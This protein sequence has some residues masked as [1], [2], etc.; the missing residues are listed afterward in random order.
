M[1]VSLCIGII[2]GGFSKCVGL[3]LRTTVTATAGTW[4]PRAFSAL[5]YFGLPVTG[6][7]PSAVFNARS[8]L[9]LGFRRLVRIILKILGRQGNRH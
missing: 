9:E 3:S 6:A 5:G 1:L 8:D 4:K 7:V 2:L